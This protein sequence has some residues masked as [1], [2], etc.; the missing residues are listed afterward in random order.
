M[1]DGGDGFGELM[2]KILGARIRHAKSV[3]ATHRPCK[4][5][6]WF[7]KCTKTAIID[8]SRVVGLAML[9]PGHFHPFE[10]D[11]FGLG[12]VLREASK[13]GAKRCLVGIGGSATNDGG[14]GMARAL[15]WRF[16]N[17]TGDP[18]IR[19]TD[20]DSL[21]RVRSPER[22]CLFKEVTVAVDVSN[23]LLGPRGATR[24]YGPQKG[25]RRVDFKRA[26][27]SLE[28]LAKEVKSE[29]GCDF[30]R[31]PGAGAAGGLGFG[32]LAFLSARLVSGFELFATHANLK[33]HLRA[34]DLV[35]TGEGALDE[36]TLMGKGVGNIAKQCRQLGIPCIGLAGIVSGE[37]ALSK[38]FT[39]TQALVD[40]TTIRSAKAK[41]AFWLARVASIAAGALGSSSKTRRTSKPQLVC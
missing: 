38:R 3:D 8:S 41:P 33:A 31:I 26:E 28:R 1:S 34:A 39:S 10:L 29:Q 25:L 20:L 6:W 37:V 17:T 22:Q 36:S 21:R 16:T 24:I 30:E 40:L 15:G 23:P 12:L 4:V 18:I 2:G 7:E 5:R 32:F 14:F 27:R 11:T 9:S 19:W 35:I 13:H